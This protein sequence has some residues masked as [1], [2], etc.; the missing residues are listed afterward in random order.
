MEKCGPG[1]AD[2]ADG[3]P[4]AEFLDHLQNDFALGRVERGRE[5]NQE[6]VTSFGI[7]AARLE[8]GQAPSRFQHFRQIGLD[9][10]ETAAGQEADPSARGIEAVLGS[11]LLAGDG[12]RRQICERMADELGFDGGGS[13]G[14]D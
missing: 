12:G 9:L 10:L 8:C 13:A 5:G 7:A 4:A 6:L 11:K 14:D 2:E 1:V 3:E